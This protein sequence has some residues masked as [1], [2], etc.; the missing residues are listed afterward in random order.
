M[1][2]NTECVQL[3]NYKSLMHSLPKNILELCEC[4]PDLFVCVIN[5]QGSF[6]TDRPTQVCSIQ[7]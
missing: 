4:M 1:F 2:H 6:Q 7:Q 3:I 5:P